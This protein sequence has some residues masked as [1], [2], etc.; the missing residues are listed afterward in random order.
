MIDRDKAFGAYIGAA[1]ADA[2]GGPVECQHA[3]R[4][5]RVYGKIKG[6]LPY[7]RPPGLMDLHAGYAIHPEPGSVTDDT[8]IRAELTRFFIETKPPRTPKMLAEYL[9]QNADFNQWPFVAVRGLIRIIR[10]EVPAEKN[11]E[12]YEQGGYVGWWTPIGILYAEDPK[13]AAA[14]AKNLCRIYKAPLEQD[15]LSGVQAGVAAGMK[16]GSDV[17]AVVN[18]V[19]DACGPL[20]RKLMERAATIGREAKDHD[21]LVDKLYHNCLYKEF[22]TARDVEL[23]KSLEPVPD[24]DDKYT[25]VLLAEQISLAM[26]AFVFSKGDPRES[27]PNVVMVGRDCDSSATAVGSWV[28]AMHGE[29]ALPKE[30]VE[31]VC[32]VN[33]KELDIRGLCEA[34]FS[35]EV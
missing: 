30:W 6:L 21:D 22:P 27:I 10:G 4:I 2:M 26:G 24:S 34:L 16:Q 33:S 3:G 29:S 25:S 17:D 13:G 8:Y 15:I 7:Q 20:A 35:V 11:G 1:I 9:F 12:T 14:E 19:L 28:G 31:A 18:A 5:K 32:T 23:P